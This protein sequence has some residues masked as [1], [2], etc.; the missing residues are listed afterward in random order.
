MQPQSLRKSSRWVFAGTVL[1]RP[2]Q[3]VSIVVLAR[4]LGP[5]GFGVVALVTSTAITL[6]AIVNVGL[7]EASNKYV[8]EFYSEDPLGAA[9]YSSTIV[10]IVLGLSVICFIALWFLRRH[11]AYSVFP[12]TTPQTTIALCLV[13]AWLNLLFALLSSLLSAV[14]LF[15]EVTLLAIAQSALLLICVA[16]LGPTGVNGAVVA[17]VCAAALPILFAVKVLWSFDARLLGFPSFSKLADLKRI[18]HFSMPIWLGALTLNP[19][20]TFTYAYL[21]RQSGGSH[22]LGLFNTA[23]GLRMLM[24]I[25]PGVLMVVVTPALIQRGG[26]YGNTD[27]Y[28]ELLNKAVSVV[29]FLTLPLLVPVLLLSDLIFVVYGRAFSESS[30]LFIPLVAAAAVAAL[31][32]PLL[33]VLVAKNKTW[34]SFGFGIAK[35]VVLVVLALWWVPRF[36]S[37]GLSLSVMISEMLF[38]FVALEYCIRI[39]AAP[40]SMRWPFY[41]CSVVI[42]ILV[43]LAMSL[44]QVTRAIMVVPLTYVVAAALIRIYP[45]LGQW[46]AELAPPRLRDPALW[47]IR[48]ITARNLWPA[49][50][51]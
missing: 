17:Y 35:S 34:W 8:A 14:Q 40:R 2:I 5:D 21:A 42:G 48:V 3:M 4:M 13:L 39:S 38:Y 10:T 41:G 43:A 44:P 19:A 33:S 12:W 49:R 32:T 50:S 20:L 9:R 23:N 28:D 30:R 47:L 24:V 11:W 31:G 6:Y 16:F 25:L 27:S 37:M 29:L 45:L 36:L 51:R 15:R 18:F 1:S 7:A 26:Q 22:E 46:L